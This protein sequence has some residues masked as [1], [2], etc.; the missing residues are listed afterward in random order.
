MEDGSSPLN[1]AGLGQ[2]FTPAHVVERMLALGKNAGRVLDPACGDGAFSSRIPGCLAIELDPRHC[3]SGALN[4]DFF[5]YPESEKFDTIIGNPPYV[6]A[7]D[8]SP[9]TRHFL[10]SSLLDG[11]ANLYLY[12]IEKCVRQLNPG[13]E[14]IFITPRDFLKA[15]GA[16]RLNTWLHDQGTIT[17]FEDL[18]DRK[19]FAGA[20]PNCAIW[21]FERGRLNHRLDDGRRMNLAGG[22]LSF[23]RG[24]YTLPFGQ[25]FTI[26][27]GA[28]SGAD[29]LF[30]SETL[31]NR[32]FV[33]SRTAQTGE[34]R[35]MIYV[36][37]QFPAGPVLEHLQ[38][39]KERLLARRVT[40]VDE[41]NWWKWGRRHMVSAQAR[42]YV[43][44]KTRA[45]RP[46]FRHDCPDYDGAVLALFPRRRDL[47]AKQLDAL[48]SALNEV[49][50][51]ELGFV[52]DGRYLFSQRSLE[53]AL[54][55]EHF[56]EFAGTSA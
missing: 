41:S 28:V 30:T 8:I 39:H 51:H 45:L 40:R 36:D 42:I 52:C 49:D 21:R 5:V 47:T 13:G 20:T 24:I 29:E 54:L 6:K 1:V 46:F 23:T 38:K 55:P 16:A 50:W 32:D 19:I 43:N 27:V 53:H 15:T 56:T 48:T 9:A 3:P 37:D 26:K 33:C 35:R 10:H 25:I 4:S 2:V 31:G 22:H 34:L 44:G 18:G 14:L 17:H 11:H 7:R 12:F